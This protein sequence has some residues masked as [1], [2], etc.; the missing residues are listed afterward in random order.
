MTDLTVSAQ[1]LE[2][3]GDKLDDLIA[4]SESVGLPLVM[5]V[6]LME[7]AK[8]EVVARYREGGL[9]LIEPDEEAGHV[10]N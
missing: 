1:V 5:L 4:Y 10:E 3:V 7:T 9:Q 2:E 8:I 6:G